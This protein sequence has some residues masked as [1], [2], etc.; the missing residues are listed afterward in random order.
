VYKVRCLSG[1]LVDLKVCL[2]E[3]KLQMKETHIEVEVM[4]AKANNM[5]KRM[6]KGA[7][8]KQGRREGGSLKISVDKI[9]KDLTLVEMVERSRTEISHTGTTQDWLSMVKSIMVMI[10]RMRTSPT[11]NGGSVFVYL[12]RFLVPL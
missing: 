7:R 11:E 5:R 10:I 12:H 9:L 1:R 3:T 8:G 4:A 2:G 6:K